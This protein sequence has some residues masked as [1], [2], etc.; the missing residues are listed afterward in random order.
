METLNTINTAP[1]E[2]EDMP[3]F[4]NM[5]PTT[6]TEPESATEEEKEAK[7]D[8][9]KEE[10]DDGSTLPPSL[11][12][13]PLQMALRPLLDKAMADDPEF[14]EE[15]RT[16]QA[17]T[18]KKKSFPECCE[19][20]MGEAYKYASEHRVG[21]FGM[22]GGDETFIIGLIKHYYDEDEIKIHKFSGAKATFTASPSAA[23]SAKKGATAKKDGKKKAG[24]EAQAHRNVADITKAITSAPATGKKKDSLN[25]GF[26]PM[27]RPE[28]DKQAKKGSREQAKSVSQIDLFA[29][30]F[31]N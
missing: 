24:K 30:F 19:F 4:E 26:V 12:F 10:K 23:P 15:V 18:D 28:T 1:T 6:G 31:T 5:E 11:Q 3:D 17:R 20:I 16:K 21:N 8:E 22:A 14:A 13:N 7:E 9:E 2:F 29:D 27:Q 25:P